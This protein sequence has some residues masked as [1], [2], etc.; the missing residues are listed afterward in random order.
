[1]SSGAAH[2]RQG[3]AIR[4]AFIMLARA[5]RVEFL[6]K[7]VE[8]RLLSATMGCFMR[9]A[10][11]DDGPGSFWTPAAQ[12]WKRLGARKT[13]MTRQPFGAQALWRL[14]AGRQT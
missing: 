10:A 7:S 13:P 3:Y 9:R 11:S 14:P 4:P 12:S 8:F 1:M 2:A 6:W 5:G